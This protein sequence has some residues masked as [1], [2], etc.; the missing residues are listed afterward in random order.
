MGAENDHGSAWNF[1]QLLDKDRSFAAQLLDDMRVVH[2][3]VQHV[4]RG[5]I[6]VQGLADNGDRPL[7]PGAKATRPGQ[8]YLHVVP[9]ASFIKG[10]FLVGIRHSSFIYFPS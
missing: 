4:D 2:Y 6:L 1:L 10:M 7:D 8:N 5:A 9:L 3:L